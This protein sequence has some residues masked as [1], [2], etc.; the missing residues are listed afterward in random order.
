MRDARCSLCK[1]QALINKVRRRIKDV[2][3]SDVSQNQRHNNCA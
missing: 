2:T 3:V 1:P